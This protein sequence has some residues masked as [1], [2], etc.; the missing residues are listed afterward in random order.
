[1]IAGHRYRGG[2]ASQHFRAGVVVVVRHLDGEQ[3]LVFERA[4]TPGSWQFPQGGL[5]GDEQP[6]EAAWRELFEETGLGPDDVMG[7]AEYPEWVAYEWPADVRARRHGKPGR[8]GQVHKWFLFDALRGDLV[9]TP[10]GTEFVDSRWVAR[11][12][13]VGHV[14]SW[15]RAAYERVLGSL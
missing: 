1:M 12:W 13:I 14:P 10:D 5:D 4:D 8:L 7:L 9:P 2:V 3:L 11:E 15:R 6:I